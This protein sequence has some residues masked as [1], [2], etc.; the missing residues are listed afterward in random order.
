VEKL[1]FFLLI[2]LATSCSHVPGVVYKDYENEK[3]FFDTH[4][5]TFDIHLENISNSNKIS[6]LIEKLVYQNRNFDD[7]ISL[8]ENEFIGN[9]Y[10]DNYLPMIG[11]D[12]TVYVYHSDLIESYTIEYYDDSFVIVNYE[13]YFYYAGAAHGLYSVGY[14]ILDVAEERI[15]CLSD[16]VNPI[17]DY[18]LKD[19]I[20]SKYEISSYLSE[21]IWPPDSVNI[22]KNNITLLWN[23]YS[24]TAYVYG[25]IEIDIQDEIC[26][27][28]LTEKAKMIKKVVGRT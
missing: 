24:I 11:E 3:L 23:T 13:K 1:A 22:Q 25:L 7:Y 16:L 6:G 28:Y 21:K 27:P 20:E 15:L 10:K 19:I 8:R 5:F 2:I 4:Q 18:V 26:E 17:P 9:A 12:G 14:Y